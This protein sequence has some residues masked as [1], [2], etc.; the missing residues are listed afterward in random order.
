[1]KKILALLMGV[2]LCA[3][4][5]ATNSPAPGVCSVTIAGTNCTLCNFCDG[6]AIATPAGKAPYTYSWS[7][8]PTGV[9]GQGTATYG[10]LCPGSYTVSITDSTGCVSTASVAI[11]QPPSPTATAQSNNINCNGSPTGSITVTASGGTGTFTYRWIPAPGTG[12][13]TANAGSLGAGTYTCTIN[14]A[15]GCAASTVTTITEPGLLSIHATSTNQTC[16]TCA[17]G[18]VTANANG[19]TA[20][21]T[22]SWEYITSSGCCASGLTAGNY[23]CCVKDA[24]HCQTCQTASVSYHVGIQSFNNTQVISLSPNP[25]T[26]SLRLELDNIP[27]E[28]IVEVYNMLGERVLSRKIVSELTELDSSTLTSGLYF[29]SIRTREENIGLRKMVKQ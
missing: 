14:D 29:V 27:A 11:S 2:F 10:R 17:D 23:T 19:G 13:N 20:P 15:N 12:Q 28:A 24:N 4:D 5:F 6:S 3:P 9:S 1:M 22:Y 8:S 21:Y 18:T 16:S 26:N 7:P 25:F